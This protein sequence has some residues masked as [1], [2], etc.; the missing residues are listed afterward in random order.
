MIHRNCPRC[1]LQIRADRLRV[2]PVI[3]DSCGFVATDRQADVESTLETSYLKAILVSSTAILLG[4]MQLANWGNYALEVI[5]LKAG[6]FV[7][8]NSVQSKERLA[9]I[10]IDLKKH[11]LAER[12]YREIAKVDPGQLMRLGKFQMSRAKYKEATETFGA[13]FARDKENLDARY[14]YARTLGESGKIDE[15]AAHYDFIL[16]AKPG[17]LQVTV[18]ENYVKHLLAADRLEQA[19]QVIESVQRRNSSVSQFMDTE[20]KTIVEKINSKG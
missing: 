5:P 15:A 4:F 3:C 8:N 16:R 2:H 17:V 12:M 7:G 9:E 10:A 6:D 1:R 14:Y 13:V 18:L 20:L 19:K 11:D